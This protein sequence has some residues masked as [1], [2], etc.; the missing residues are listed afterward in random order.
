[1]LIAFCGCTNQAPVNRPESTPTTIRMFTATWCAACKADE[2]RLERLARQ[3]VVIER[4]DVDANP[5][6]AGQFGVVAIPAYFQ[7]DYATG[8]WN[9][10]RIR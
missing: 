2:P 8:T 7:L 3:G 9:R 10:I 4:I 1:M 5:E 6:L